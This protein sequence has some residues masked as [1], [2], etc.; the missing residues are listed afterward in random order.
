MS[1]GDYWKSGHFVG[2]G[3]AQSMLLHGKALLS[4]R[5]AAKPVH[6]A[7]PW[8]AETFPGEVDLW[9]YPDPLDFEVR[10]RSGKRSARAPYAGI[11]RVF[12]RVLAVAEDLEEARLRAQFDDENEAY[13]RWEQRVADPMVLL[14]ELAQPLADSGEAGSARDLGTFRMTSVAGVPGVRWRTAGQRRER[15]FP[16]TVVG[17]VGAELPAVLE[18]L[19]ARQAGER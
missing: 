4:T 15:F 11:R 12:A 8:R 16:L 14:Q 10:W 5:A 17:W 6:L 19:A 18:R 13:R 1:T 3:H 7:G 2:S 9:V